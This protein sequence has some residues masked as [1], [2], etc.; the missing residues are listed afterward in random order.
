M[1]PVATASDPEPRTP[2]PEPDPGPPMANILLLDDSDVAG[3]A[4]QGILVRAN[5]RCA[6]ASTAEEAWQFLREQVKIDLVFVELKLK[7]ENGIRFIQRVRGDAF[8]KPLPIVVYTSVGE[9][10]VVRAALALK[11]Q[12]YLV[13]PYHEDSIYA[14]VA[15][16]GLNPWRN[17]H[18]E[19]ER[20]FCAQLGLQPEELRRQR[21]DLMAAI[22]DARQFFA[23]NADGRQHPEFFGRI[24]ALSGLAE[25]AGVW[26]VVDFMSE[27]RTKAESGFWTDFKRCPDDLG[28]AWHLIFCHLNPAHVPHG[29]TSEKERRE[30]EDARE[31]AFWLESDVKASGPLVTPAD[32]SRRLDAL[33]GCPVIDSVAAAFQM[34]ADGRVASLIH[35]IDLVTRDP[36][37]CAQV[38]VAA[39]HIEREETTPIEDPRLGV[40]LLGELRLHALGRALP[41]VEERLMCIPPI[42]WPHF[43]Q[44]QI[45]VARMAQYTA[46]YLGFR[47]L[48]ANAYTAGLLHDLGK[49][50]LVQ[51]YPYGFQAMVA[52]AKREN[53][54]LTEAERRYIGC[55]TREIADHFARQSGLPEVFASVI[56]WAEAPAQATAHAELVA[57]VSLARHVCL[58]NH[59]GYCGDTPKDH[60]PPIAETEAWQVLAS[61]V[62]PSFDLHNFECQA[63]A[64]CL[65]LKQALAGRAA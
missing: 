3:R 6:V 35:V 20:S 61:R 23:A 8:L 13:K 30:S 26:A 12:N 37:L 4:M 29:F 56:R 15:K 31:R 19:E 7:G 32:V 57:V 50:L 24:E 17:L 62:F 41:T 53:I 45:G 28:Y 16:A 1:A 40:S 36:G 60:C 21:Q 33:P 14:E 5:H 25:A 9:Q 65:E 54:P 42:T 11:V 34:V 44:F 10:A 55:T 47:G 39:N 46:K 51:L 63:H 27:L 49:I 59:V 58:H 48:V 38:L 18:F 22:E 52:H 2:N 64:F 43:W